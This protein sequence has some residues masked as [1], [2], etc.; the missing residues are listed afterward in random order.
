MII[1]ITK[2]EADILSDVCFNNAGIGGTIE[3]NSEEWNN[4]ANKIRGLI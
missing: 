3:L 1:K 2:K 4:L